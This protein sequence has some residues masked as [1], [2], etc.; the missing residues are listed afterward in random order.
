M[1][2][3]TLSRN[4]W[5]QNTCVLHRAFRMLLPCL[6]WGSVPCS[7]EQSKCNLEAGSRLLHPLARELPLLQGLLS[8][9][10]GTARSDWVR[11]AEMLIFQKHKPISV[12]PKP[13]PTCC[14]FFATWGTHV[15]A[16]GHTSP[17]SSGEHL[18]CLWTNLYLS[19]WSNSYYNEC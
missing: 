5:H 13:L 9:L 1:A 2:L 12:F 4:M 19:C 11:K 14:S 3:A 7:Y 17:L 15:W 10:S 16:A 8:L 6:G 18:L